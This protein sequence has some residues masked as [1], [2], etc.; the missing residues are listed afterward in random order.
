M[1]VAKYKR[2]ESEFEVINKFNRIRTYTTFYILKDFGIKGNVSEA[3]IA[4]LEEERYAIID[5][6]R[7]ISVEINLAN[8]IYVT[9][10]VEY[11]QRRL[12]Q[13]NAIGYMQ[14][15]Y[16]ELQYVID[17]FKDKEKASACKNNIIEKYSKNIIE[18]NN[19]DGSNKNK[20]K[21]KMVYTKIQI[22]INKYKTLLQMMEEEFIL[23]RAW[24]KKENPIGAK[25]RKEANNL[26]EMNEYK[27]KIQEEIL[28][29][30]VDNI[31]KPQEVK[32]K[33]KKNMLKKLSDSGTK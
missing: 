20:V 10:Y 21:K 26:F 31:D 19:D 6:M 33:F 8:D 13:D 2:K 11:E 12:H 28:D 22:N 4:F 5:L 1:S 32:D 24:R 30:I 9:N 29:I 18:D 15:L 14:N 7:K 16:C 25:Y 23:L 27:F 3:E 17:V